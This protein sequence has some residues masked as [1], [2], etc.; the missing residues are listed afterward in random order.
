ML[1]P[2]KIGILAVCLAALNGAALAGD[3]PACKPQ[4]LQPL[5]ATPTSNTRFVIDL[6]DYH[7]TYDIIAQSAGQN[8]RFSC[9]MDRR[10]VC[11]LMAD[12]PAQGDWQ[13]AF[14]GRYP[15]G[16]PTQL[17]FE[18]GRLHIVPSPLSNEFVVHGGRRIVLR[19]SAL[20]KVRFE[21]Q[22]NHGYSIEDWDCVKAAMRAAWQNGK[23]Y[24]TNLIKGVPQLMSVDGYELDDITASDS[25]T[26]FSH[27][28]PYF[29]RDS[30]YRRAVRFNP[31]RR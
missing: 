7:G 21:R 8:R 26:G 30:R 23:D 12:Q 31:N 1:I 25:R 22:N 9:P 11:D 17:H 24:R 27:I 15:V 18:D 5:C 14:S 4:S 29:E 16:G 3:P 19:P 28:P 6:G 20:A 10:C 2:F 13:L